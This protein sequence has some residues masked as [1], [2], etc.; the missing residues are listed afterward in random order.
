VALTLVKR[1]QAENAI[2]Q[3]ELKLAESDEAAYRAE[4]LI[5]GGTR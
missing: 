4:M 3:A 1:Q 2:H 5:R